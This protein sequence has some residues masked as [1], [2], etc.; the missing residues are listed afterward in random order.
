MSNQK[1]ILVVED[2]QD[3]N[4]AMSMF[5]KSKGY[6]VL[7]AF[8]GEEGVKMALENQPD[9]ILMDY[10]MP[11]MTGTDAIAEIR[12]DIGWGEASKIVM[13]T[14]MNEISTIND[15]IK[16]GVND[17]LLKSDSP[18]ED[19]LKIVESHLGTETESVQ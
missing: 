19:V 1:T 15:A 12:N 14:N 6:N 13:M 11:V 10:L 3:L 17:Y 16:A 18:L 7:S 5:L 9:L 2:V 4:E 8:N